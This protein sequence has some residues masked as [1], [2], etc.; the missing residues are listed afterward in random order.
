[1]GEKRGGRSEPRRKP[2]GRAPP[3]PPPRRCR[4]VALR[5][6]LCWLLGRGVDT[7]ASRPTPPH[8]PRIGFTVSDQWSKLK[9]GAV[10]SG[11]KPLTGRTRWGSHAKRRVP[12]ENTGGLS[13]GKTEV[14]Q[15]AKR[16]RRERLLPGSRKLLRFL[17]LGSKETKNREIARG[18]HGTFL[19]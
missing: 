16:G 17:F 14:G 6:A 18:S 15:G 11:R 2:R 10:I 12:S 13:S 8:S 5:V 7:A 4:A 19:W 9:R 1:M 3:P